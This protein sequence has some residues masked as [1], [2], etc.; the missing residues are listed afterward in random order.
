MKV[1]VK[2]PHVGVKKV[3]VKAPRVTYKT[4]APN[5]PLAQTLGLNEPPQP[6]LRGR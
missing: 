3:K 6:L 5:S 4:K 2:A 1:R